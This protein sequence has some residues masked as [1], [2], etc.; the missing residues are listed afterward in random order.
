MEK[1]KL[2]LLILGSIILF[3]LG[4]LITYFL[5][6][7]TGQVNGEANKLDIT[8]LDNEKEYDGTQ[9]N[10]EEYEQEGLLDGHSI[11][12]EYLGGITDVGV[13]QS[14]CN[15]KVFDGSGR[16]VT[17]DYSIKINKGN[18]EVTK[19]PITLSIKK[20]GTNYDP[21]A[22]VETNYDN[23]I[24]DEIDYEIVSNIKL[25]KGHRLVPDFEVGD[26]QNVEALDGEESYGESNVNMV[27]AIYDINGFDV[28]SNY[29]ISYKDN[30]KI[31]IN[32]PTLTLTTLSF[33]KEYDGEP[34]DEDD[35]TYNMKG[36]LPK[37]YSIDVKY[38][39]N[40]ND[41]VNV[42]DSGLLVIDT[43][44]TKITDEKGN[45]VT[46]NYKILA[47]NVGSLSI[48]P[49]KLHLHVDDYTAEYDGEMHY[50]DK[51]E[52]LDDEKITSINAGSGTT[53]FMLN[54]YQYNIDIDDKKYTVMTD[55]G[56]KTNNLSYKIT[57]DNS[58]SSENLASNF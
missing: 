7:A 53:G 20:A 6:L 11:Q 19:R 36:E 28:T 16:E 57:L 42:D 31:K 41:I 29:A 4:V 40:I 56:S 10:A 15:V 12:I 8:I 37:N 1:T 14:D 17:N 23:D 35:I 47:Q 45:D 38:V 30:M 18:L 13:G 26:I 2:S 54:G 43:R 46:S 22:L 25:C 5:L 49:V 44:N 3:M 39:N 55:V 32:K 27:A 50:Y 58:T 33:T 21:N 52:I 48:T 34:F 24:T 9:L 51:F